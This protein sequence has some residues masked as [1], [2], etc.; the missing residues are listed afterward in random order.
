MKREK[1]LFIR[2]GPSIS[3]PQE[4][5]RGRGLPSSFSLPFPWRAPKA[6]ALAGCPG[7]VARWLWLPCS[8]PVVATLP[9]MHCIREGGISTA[10]VE[11][12][13]ELMEA[14][15]CVLYS[16]LSV[17]AFLPLPRPLPLPLR[18][19]YFHFTLGIPAPPSSQPPP[20]LVLFS[21]PA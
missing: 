12:G 6:P 8:P 3:E 21:S 5:P 2:S 20:S 10:M 13:R 17:G 19:L 16:V 7:R 11:V 9:A 15:C 4:T 1:E 14:C 18:I